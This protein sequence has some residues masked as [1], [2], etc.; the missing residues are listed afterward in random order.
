[1][2]ENSSKYQNIW[3]LSNIL[4]LL[5]AATT[6]QTL[7]LRHSFSSH[8]KPPPM[9][10]DNVPPRRTILDVLQNGDEIV[11]V[12]RSQRSVNKRVRSVHLNAAMTGELRRLRICLIRL[13][14]EVELSYLLMA[15]V[16]A[17]RVQQGDSIE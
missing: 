6:Q 15:V 4:K 16:N 2:T 14:K 11:G 1:M 8:L 7:R 17:I 3:L 9:A 5:L 10:A 13:G 12:R